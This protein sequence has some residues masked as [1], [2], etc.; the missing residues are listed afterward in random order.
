MFFQMNSIWLKFFGVFFE[1]LRGIQP[2]KTREAKWC[3]HVFV[4]SIMDPWAKQTINFPQSFRWKSAHQQNLRKNHLQGKWWTLGSSLTSLSG[5]RGI[6]WK[7]WAHLPNY[8]F[9]DFEPKKKGSTVG[10][11]LNVSK[12]KCRN[13]VTIWRMRRCV[14]FF[15]ALGS[16]FIFFNLNWTWWV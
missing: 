10:I 7:I 13:R 1:P 11:P 5:E 16:Y 9:P 8:F 3:R 15:P 4:G 6:H 14:S 12:W 2:T